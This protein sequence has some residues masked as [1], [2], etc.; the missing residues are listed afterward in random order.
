L[1]NLCHSLAIN[2][3]M[4]FE[5]DLRRFHNII[6]DFKGAN[7]NN[8]I[9]SD[10]GLEQGIIGLEELSKA[11]FKTLYKTEPSDVMKALMQATFVRCVKT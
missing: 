10:T 2:E 7:K 6:E 5:A 9:D 8:K 3:E 4:A 1:S 11:N